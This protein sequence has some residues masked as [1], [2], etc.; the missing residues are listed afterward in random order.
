MTTG[1]YRRGLADGPSDPSMQAPVTVMPPVQSTSAVAPQPT[2][3]N[4]VPQQP[5]IGHLECVQWV[6]LGLL[7][8]HFARLQRWIS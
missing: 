6:A 8:Y 5:G 4:V 7:G 2:I 3:V 1:Y